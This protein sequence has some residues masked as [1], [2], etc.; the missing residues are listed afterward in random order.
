MTVIDFQ[1]ARRSMVVS[2]VRTWEVLDERVLDAMAGLAREEFVPGC[3]RNL[4]FV[5]TEIPI[6][7]AQTMAAPKLVGRMLQSLKVQARDK[8]LEVG[9]GTGYSTALLANLANDGHVYSV[10]IH[11]DFTAAA[12]QRLKAQ[13]IRNVTLE[14]GNAVN[15]WEQHEPYDVIAITGSLPI[16]AAGF[17]N[18]RDSLAVGGRLFVIVGEVPTMDATLITRLGENEWQTHKL[19][20]TVTPPLLHAPRNQKFVL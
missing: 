1:Q 8:V 10:D 2:Q 11:P 3:Y 12:A 4:A 7:Q 17:Q 13:G 14:T 9:T 6:G 16:L 15:G 19:F 5:D 20:E 18:F